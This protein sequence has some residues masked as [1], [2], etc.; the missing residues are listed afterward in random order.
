MSRMDRYYSNERNNITKRSEKN[1]D[2]Y[3]NIYDDISYSNIEG[4]ATIEKDNEVDIT[5]VKN[6]LKN[7]EE[8]QRQ[9]DLRN[10]IDEKIEEPK[11][12]TFERDEDRVYDIRDILDKAKTNKKQQKYHNLDEKNVELLKKLKEQ[13]KEEIPKEQVESMIDTIHNTSK[14]SKLTE[15]ELGLD[16]LEDLKSNN[17]TMI[18]NKD[19]IKSILNEVKKMDAKKNDVTNTNIDKSFF[20][21]SMSFNDEDFEGFE[22]PKTKKSVF[23]KILL[24]VGLIAISG[25]VVFVVF[26]VLK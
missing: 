25:L 8:F 10:F 7:R 13:S 3:K 23:L 14:I 22:K 19:S 2:L 16:M 26:N 18:G 15:E 6:L 1:R 11:Y 12:E 21:S 5:K 9:K 20:T 4:I 17:N 24:F